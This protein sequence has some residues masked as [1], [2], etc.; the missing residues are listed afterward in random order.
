MNNTPLTAIRQL[1]FGLRV[2]FRGLTLA[3]IRR[4]AVFMVRR[5][6][7]RKPVPFSVVYA[8][9]YK[10]QC[11]C[12]HCSVADYGVP[13]DEFSTEEALALVDDIAAWGAVKVTFFGGEPLVRADLPELVERATARGL[14]SSLDTNGLFLDAKMG[15]RLKAA[16]IGNINVSLDSADA[17]VHDAL[18]KQPGCFTAAVSAIRTCVELKIPCLVSTYASKRALKEGD[19]QRVVALARDLGAAG[20]KIL[21]PI[22]SGNWR[23]NEDERLSADEEKLLLGLMD[24]A[25]VYL[26]DALQMV[27]SRG[28][29]CSAMER[30]LAYISPTGEVQPCPAIPV[31]FGNIREQSL[32]GIAAAMEGHP[33]FEK[34]GKCSMCLMNEPGFRESLF[35]RGPA[36]LPVRID[37]LGALLEKK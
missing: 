30:N 32:A 20:V 12:V 18:R 6:L 17:A 23:K 8:V 16:G 25:Y 31:S 14:R 5:F 2:F 11:R 1:R 24:P 28:K 36:R 22:L 10:C 3:N 21:F 7:L 15:A 27:K 29:G 9:T 34:Y 37:E 26:E 33:F 19:M 35:A 13:A 4:I